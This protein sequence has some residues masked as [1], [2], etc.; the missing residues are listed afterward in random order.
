[1]SNYPSEGKEAGY[2]DIQKA[3]I[4]TAT[5]AAHLKEYSTI[6]AVL[7]QNDGAIE[8]LTSE[9][10]DLRRKLDPISVRSDSVEGREPDD[11]VG[12]NSEIYYQLNNQATSILHLTRLIRSTR[13]EL[14]I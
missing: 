8:K 11:L 7:D 3:A 1:M 14:E 2:M 9:F 10:L 5:Q 13:E 4:G 6:K 12:G